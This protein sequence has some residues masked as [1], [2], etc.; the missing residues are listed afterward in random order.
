MDFITRQVVDYIK[1]LGIP[2]HT[3]EELIQYLKDHGYENIQ[4]AFEEQREMQDIRE[5][6]I[7][8]GQIIL[9]SRCFL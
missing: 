2:V 3:R 4:Q 1:S 6:A 5:R 8:N 7:N 9:Q